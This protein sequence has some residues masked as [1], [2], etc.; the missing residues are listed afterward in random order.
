MNSGRYWKIIIWQLAAVGV[1]VWFTG[2]KS[3]GIPLGFGR[4]FLHAVA[5]WLPL[6]AL[7]GGG[8]LAW[9]W[10]LGNF[11]FYPYVWDYAAAACLRRAADM[12]DEDQRWV[13]RYADGREMRGTGVGG[14]FIIAALAGTVLLWFAAFILGPII[15]R[16]YTWRERQAL[17]FNRDRARF[18]QAVRAE[19]RLK[20]LLGVIVLGSVAYAFL[21]RK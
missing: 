21:G 15:A 3:F 10:L 20:L 5:G 18:A 1:Y 8:P 4:G 17:H 11:F 7:F 14:M 2:D 9:L 16:I 13:T 6:D 19:K 12:N